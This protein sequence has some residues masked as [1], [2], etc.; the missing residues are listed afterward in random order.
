MSQVTS[1]VRALLELGRVSNLPTVWSNCLAAWT[2]ASGSDWKR[3]ALVCSGGSFLYLAGMFLNDAF[4]VDFDRK[5]RPERP[6]IRGGISLRMVW[7]LGVALLAI[8]WG[9]IVS[10]GLGPLIIASLLAAMIVI[11]DAVHKHF[12]PAPFLMAACRF[13]LYLLAAMSAAGGISTEL[14][15][16]AVALTAYILGLSLIARVESSPGYIGRWPMGLLFV[17]IVVG[18]VFCKTVSVMFGVAAATQLAWLLWCLQRKSVTGSRRVG[19]GVAGLLAGIALV[20]WL[21]AVAHAPGLS[22]V[23][24][25]LFLLALMLQRL[26]P[27]T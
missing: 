17:P 9:V 18:L 16:R 24:L 20:D 10:L 2:L 13:L 1:R 7:T 26:A 4:D 3:F 8:G 22:P 6:I 15:W 21:A 14:I 12:S 27:A 19:A 25:A 23:F 11:Y 5:H